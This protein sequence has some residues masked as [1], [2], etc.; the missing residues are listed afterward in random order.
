MCRGCAEVDLTKLEGYRVSRAEQAYQ[1]L[2]NLIIEGSLAPGTHLSEPVL[3]RALGMSRTPVREALHRLRQEGRVASTSGVGLHVQALAPQTAVEIVGIRAVL[4]AY[5]AGLAATRMSAEAFGTLRGMLV[6]SEEADEAEELDRL[7]DCN[8]R[9]HDAI[10]SGS[11]SRWC[12]QMVAELRDW[13][14]LI[15]RTH[16]LITMCACR[17][18][19]TMRRSSSRLSRVIRLELKPS[20]A[21]TY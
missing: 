9:F 20:C 11:G 5:A 12:V 18:V 3:A 17:V 8:T 14:R 4:E 1:A 7:A 16:S 2:R 19:R 15:A 6:K 13:V 10:V 21:S